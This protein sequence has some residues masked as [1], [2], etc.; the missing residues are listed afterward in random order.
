MQY[1]KPIYQPENFNYK[2]QFKKYLTTKNITIVAIILFAVLFFFLWFSWDSFK[3]TNIDFAIIG[4]KNTSTAQESTFI[5]YIK[6]KNRRTLE[7]GE[8]IFQYPNGFVITNTDYKYSQFG[9]SAI[10]FQLNPLKHNQ[11]NKINIKAIVGGEKEENK[12]LIAKFSYNPKNLNA[13]FENTTAFSFYI[14]FI[15]ITLTIN[16][17]EKV[18]NNSEVSYLLNYVNTSDQLFKNLIIEAIFP[19]G[20]IF[21]SSDPPINYDNKTWIINELKPGIQGSIII[22]G[23]ISGQDNEVKKIKFTIFTNNNEQKISLNSITAENLIKES[24][25]KLIGL[26]NESND[27]SANLGDNLNFKLKFRNNTDVSLTNVK[28]KVELVGNLFNIK[29]LQNQ[30]G[31]FDP[32][33]NSL[34]WTSVNLPQL[35]TLNPN[36]E[37]EINF[38]IQLNKSIPTISPNTKNPTVKF[39][40]TV[41]TE[42]PP[43]IFNVEKLEQKADY[44]IKI[45]TQ[46]GLT[47]KALYNDQKI[48]NS[49][50]TP[51]KVGQ[52]T[53][54]SIH[55]IITNTTGDLNN[56]E[57]KTILPLNVKWNNNFT[58]TDGT[59][60]F[61]SQTNEVLWK[62]NKISAG[63][64]FY[65]PIQEAIF[66][67]AL[68]PSILDL[69][70]YPLITNE[71]ELTA[72][73]IFVNLPL[74]MKSKAKDVRLIDDPSYGGKVQ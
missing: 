32:I 54:Y 55:W 9:D 69:G 28:I 22:K 63:T 72:D 51:P 4:P 5:I 48:Q 1:Y 70:K 19:D 27:Q 30:N 37:G 68:T 15:P 3:Q 58:T 36:D 44:L 65:Q 31:Y 23:I 11:E 12:N 52:T 24:V 73:E 67:V 17:A 7:N 14:K 60:S 6:N 40:V 8:L 20:F 46:T 38:N 13:R 49:G 42:T 50:P 56:I 16:T 47:V 61:N 34:I 18:F 74:I 66:Q 43:T 45:R 29:S 21:K 53:T 71:T 26:I 59:L 39:G 2:S 64:G 10:K 33:N 41:F 25:F 62:I 57:I 35:E